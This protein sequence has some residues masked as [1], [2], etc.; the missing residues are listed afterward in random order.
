MHV[1]KSLATL[2][3]LKGQSQK[4]FEKV[5]FGNASLSIKLSNNENF[6]N[7]LINKA[8][9]KRVYFEEE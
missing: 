6:D 1:G 9:G 7:N 4:K 8:F 5:N 3:A 2:I